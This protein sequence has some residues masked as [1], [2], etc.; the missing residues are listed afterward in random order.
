M[1]RRFHVRDLCEL[2]ESDWEQW[3]IRVRVLR[4]LTSLLRARGVSEERTTD[5][6]IENI[7]FVAVALPVQPA[8]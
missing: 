8:V 6:H 4:A 3:L 5:E 1:G 2:A 7:L